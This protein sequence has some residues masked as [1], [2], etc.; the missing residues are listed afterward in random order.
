MPAKQG[1]TFEEKDIEGVG[2]EGSYFFTDEGVKEGMENES[3]TY[4]V[5]FLNIA[6]PY[7]ASNLNE[8]TI[9]DIA[10]SEI[11]KFR[12]IY[13]GVDG[14]EIDEEKTGLTDIGGIRFLKI[15]SVSSLADGAIKLRRVNYETVQNG[16]RYS[17]MF[18]STEELAE[19]MEP[20]YEE[21]LATFTIK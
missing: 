19:R 11:E 15:V 21:V 18:S 8:K 3:F 17:F 12:H 10:D 14:M 7:R 9:D 16:S 13:E 2:F 1:Y 5:P 20:E 4:D 6:A